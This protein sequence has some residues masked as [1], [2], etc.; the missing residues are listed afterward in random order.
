MASRRLG[1]RALE[2]RIVF[3]AAAA[4]TAAAATP[5]DDHA[6]AA[7]L[8]QTLL[9]ANAADASPAD[10]TDHSLSAQVLSAPA[11]TPVQAQSPTAIVFVDTSVKDYRQFVE[12][13][14]PGA[15]VVMLDPREEGVSQIADTLGRYSD[16]QSVHIISHGAQGELHLGSTVLDA[17]SLGQHAG[18]LAVWNKGLAD[19]ADI[20][21]YGCDVGAGSAGQSFINGLAALTGADV[22]ASTDPTGSAA[23]GGD[24]ELES[25]SG[26]IGT[27]ALEARGYEGLLAAPTFLYQRQGTG[28]IETDPLTS[29]VFGAFVLEQPDGR[30][31][32]GGE[33]SNG[34]IVLVRYLADGSLDGSFGVDGEALVETGAS[35]NAS[36]RSAVLQVDGK[37]VV[38][39][40]AFNGTDTDV[41]VWRFNTDGSL[42][43]GFGLNGRVLVGIG[44]DDEG[45]A[46]ALDAD[47]RIVVAGGSY[48]G[49]SYDVAL[50]RLTSSGDLDTSFDVDGKLLTDISGGTEEARGIAVQEDGRIVVVGG[51]TAVTSSYSD[52]LVARYNADGSLDTTF[53]GTSTG[54]IVTAVDQ[55]ADRASGVAIDASGNIVVAGFS[56]MNGSFGVQDDTALLRYT[57]AGVLD[58]SFGADASGI[59]RVSAG[60]GTDTADA[61]V[62]QADGSIVT[63][64]R[65][66][67][68]FGT[69]AAVLRFDASGVLDSTF[70]TAGVG[71]YAGIVLTPYFYLGT[72]GTFQLQSV[73]IDASGRIVAAGSV[74]Y[75]GTQ[76]GVLRYNPDGSPDTSFGTFIVDS[77]SEG[78][79]IF[80]QDDPGPITLAQGARLF[81]ADLAALSF[82][83]G[84]YAGLS[85]TIA[86][87]GGAS[88]DDVLGM[89]ETDGTVYASGGVLTDSD[90]FRFGAYSAGTGTL[91][92]TFDSVDNAA[93]QEYV[94]ATLRLVT[95]F[96]TA[97]LP[98]T[99]VSMQ[100]T[101]SDGS[102]TA[103]GNSQVTIVPINEAPSFDGDLTGDG[104]TIDT[105][106]AGDLAA[107]AVI[108]LDDGRYLVTGS[109][110]NASGNYD[111][112]LRRYNADGT[113]DTTFGDGG[114]VLTDFAGD[115]D[116][117]YAI[118]VQP[119]GRILVAGS[120]VLSS[121][122]YDFA[123]A[124]YTADG[125]LDGSFGTAGIALFD[126][127]FG[128]DEAYGITVMPDGSILLAGDAYLAESLSDY[129]VALVKLDASGALDPTFGSG[130]RVTTSV[131]AGDSGYSLAVDASGRVLVAGESFN[132][133]DYDFLV[134]RYL[135]DGSLDSTFGV[136]GSVV[137]DLLDSDSGTNALTVQADGSIVVVGN[138]Q[139]GTGD[140]DIAVV[141]YLAD[142]SLDA[143]FGTAGVVTVDIAG[144]YDTA[145]G[146]AMSGDKIVVTGSGT[147]TG[148][149]IDFPTFDE[150]LL[151]LRLNADGSLD[152]AF[153]DAGIARLDFGNFGYAD[154]TYDSGTLS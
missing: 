42:D 23:L 118:T 72:R 138:V 115:E 122:T 66:S 1:I 79:P 80:F 76:F 86:R 15:L 39:G 18:D 121:G 46:V 128:A 141:R 142:G 45:Y 9:H 11:P 60:L 4:A 85:V 73:S 93:S 99:S 40:M 75:A 113:P 35:F 69:S 127:E 16:V 102:S 153:G 56:Q 26:N 108:R 109:E 28:F 34:Q 116:E 19:G 154:I 31:I 92:I 139:N 30:L 14:P 43:T 21:L 13:S 83:F 77:L 143:G 74:T 41:A 49:S 6:A 53:G 70:G 37:I 134:V 20:L 91:T 95:Y 54:I 48:N 25:R 146:V 111:F 106:S 119:D 55:Y 67:D 89:I 90:G 50:L 144:G 51:A 100:W 110:V 145:R 44:N 7:S 58:T 98:P 114:A 117:A 132:G 2:K 101:A 124:R 94:N 125:Q 147:L 82:G 61:V 62:I 136:G 133:T 130:G 10:H 68:Y 27:A 59:V 151:V 57:A 12:Q 112:A 17:D 96:N 32:V 149:T 131:G 33:S 24:W 29:S 97:L 107:N 65:A 150:D 8:L 52:V 120:A 105:G 64:G 63:A 152:A 22:A 135:A 87:E 129:A 5:A 78:S 103:V 104:I 36:A 47:G 137:T 81:D 148:G 126:F 123:V 38:A 3:D 84:D 88:A 71:T 140:Y